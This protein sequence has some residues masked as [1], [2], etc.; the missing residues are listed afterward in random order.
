ME[1]YFN[2]PECSIS[3]DQY[4]SEIADIPVLS[5]DQ[6]KVLGFEADK[7]NLEARN[8]LIK[9][10]LKYVVSL[11]KKLNGKGVPLADLISEGNIGLLFAAE[12]FDPNKGRFSTYAS[13]WINKSMYDAIKD[14]SGITKTENS[15]NRFDEYKEK[16]KERISNRYRKAVNDI[17][18]FAWIEEVLSLDQPFNEDSESDMYSFL[19]DDNNPEDIVISNSISSDL[20]DILSDLP[21]QE[22][23]YLTLFFGLEGN[24]PMAVEE[25]A[26]AYKMPVGKVNRAIKNTL[27]TLRTNERVK[28]LRGFFT[29]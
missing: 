13:Y 3:L 23:A 7:G 8:T 5:E 24:K 28:K 17:Q 6:E 4:F 9:S 29:E 22:Q 20:K 10:H 21:P 26:E 25:I 16:L 12:E 18:P 27:R 15:F 14:R 1:M 11:A 19:A 2:Q